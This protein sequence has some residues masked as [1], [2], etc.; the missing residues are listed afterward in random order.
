MS[1]SSSPA[2][3]LA[4]LMTLTACADA[5][6]AEAAATLHEA[7]PE[8]HAEPHARQA[9]QTIAHLRDAL[10]A[11]DAQAVAR[12]T[13]LVTGT[14]APD[15]VLALALHAQ[16]R[17]G[18]ALHGWARALLRAS[19]TRPLADV[20]ARLVLGGSLQQ[21]A[22]QRF[23]AASTTTA[24]RTP[25]AAAATLGYWAGILQAALP[26]AAPGED[27]R[28]KLINRLLADAAT[29]ADATPAGRQWRDLN[30]D[31]DTARQMPPDTRL[32]RALR[33]LAVKRMRPNGEPDIET[34]DASGPFSA[35]MSEARRVREGL[36]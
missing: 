30:L 23:N 13:A 36:K 11:G 1:P 5:Q 35:F 21:P 31:A 17:D 15:V 3:L 9:A 24:A 27:A 6:A 12:V 19:N 4:C 26:S 10:K 32:A 25:Y 14:Q 33:P 34:A 8:S 20:L 16:E 7:L 22:P 18:R 28:G 2:W 29:L